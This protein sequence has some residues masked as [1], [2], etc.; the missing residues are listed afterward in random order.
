MHHSRKAMI[1]EKNKEKVW[2]KLIEKI[3][4]SKKY[5]TYL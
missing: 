4:D 5:Y 1:D 3:R 2:R